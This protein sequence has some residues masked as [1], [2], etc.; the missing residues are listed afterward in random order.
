MQ[1]VATATHDR[2]MA[3][4]A[5]ATGQ[6]FTAN[7]LGARVWAAFVQREPL[8]AVIDAISREYG[9]VASTVKKDVLLFLTSL[10]RHGLVD[11]ERGR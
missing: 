3:L 4:F 11:A 7:A 1:A 2:G 5:P 9:V 10:K 6:V 8:D